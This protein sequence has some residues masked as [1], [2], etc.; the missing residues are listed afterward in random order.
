MVSDTGNQAMQYPIPTEADD[1]VVE[2]PKPPRKPKTDQKKKTKRKKQ[3][4]S[5]AK[6]NSKISE[7][8]RVHK[9]VT[10]KN[11]VKTDISMGKDSSKVKGLPPPEV[12]PKIYELPEPKE[13]EIKAKRIISNDFSPPA[14]MSK[15]EKKK[16]GNN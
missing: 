6:L 15:N 16:P 14:K 9:E 4:M 7:F 3:P 1:I 8:E 11:T 5:T 10:G 2:D 13:P 12:E